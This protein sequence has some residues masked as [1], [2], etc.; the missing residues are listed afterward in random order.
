MKNLAEV[1]LNGKSL[2][3][4][5]KEPFRVEVT[6]AV[7][8]GENDLQIKVTNLWPNRLIGDQKLP[9][10]DRTTWAFVSLYK[11]DEPLLP[12][13]LLGLS[14]SSQFRA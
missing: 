1:S 7:Q 5:W 4:L 10:K 12:S 11:G 6:E 14:R 9:E 3:T 2:V 13:G 8:E